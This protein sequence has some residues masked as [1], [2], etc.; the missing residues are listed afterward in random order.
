MTAVVKQDTAKTH[1]S[2]RRGEE[3]WKIVMRREM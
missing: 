1:I 2:V 3:R